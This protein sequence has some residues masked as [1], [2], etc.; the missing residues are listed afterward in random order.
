MAGALRG[1]LD[2]RERMHGESTVPK[3]EKK[4]NVS[5]G[6]VVE[7]LDGIGVSLPSILVPFGWSGSLERS[8][9]RRGVRLWG[10]SAHE[11]RLEHPLNHGKVFKVSVIKPLVNILLSG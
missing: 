7:S 9:T 6:Q 2:W 11:R 5:S 8:E 1:P 10:Y 4:R 3:V